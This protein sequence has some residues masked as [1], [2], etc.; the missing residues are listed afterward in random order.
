MSSSY[1][2]LPNFFLVGAARCGTTLLHSLLAEHSQVY[3]C[4]TKEPTFFS[5]PYQHVKNPVDYAAEFEGVTDE[6]A[7]GEASHGYLTNPDSAKTL[8]AFFPDA[9][10][11]LIVRNPADRARALYSL[12]RA[13]GWEFCST[14]ERALE[15]EDK[16]YESDFYRNRHPYAFWNFMYYRS[17]LFGEQFQRYLDLY[18]RDQFY[19]TTLYDLTLDPDKIYGEICDFLE[20]DRE[21]A[22]IVTKVNS[23]EGFTWFPAKFVERQVVKRLEF[24]GVPMANHLAEVLRRVNDDDVPDFAPQ[25]R[26]DLVDRFRPDLELFEQLSGVD[27]L[28]AEQRK[29]DAKASNR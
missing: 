20:I 22:P 6:R 12:N 26:Q 1:G 3:F 23:S 2:R 17:G 13:T 24:R 5:K 21:P 14:L 10:F 19:V 15:V 4:P 8:R 25:T 27:V 16:R 7:I 18:P 11:V 28:A 29:L 9:K